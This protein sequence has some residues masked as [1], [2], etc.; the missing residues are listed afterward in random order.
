MSDNNT[1]IIGAGITGLAAAHALRKAGQTP[2]VLESSDRAGGRIKTVSYRGD[3]AEAGGQGIHTNYTEMYKL[4]DEHRLLGDLIP[5]PERTLYIDKKG[6]PRISRVKEDLALMVGPRGIADLL[7]FRRRV[8]SKTNANPQFEIALDIP[9]YDNV[10]AADGFRKYGTAFRDFVLKTATH[11]MANTTPEETNLYY[12]M[13]AVKL[14]LSTEISSL[15]GGNQRILETMAARHDMRYGVKVDKL[16]TS[17]GRVDGVLLDNGQTMKAS[18]VIVTTPAPIA[19]SLLT[20][21]FQPVK[22][23]LDSFPETPL[24]LVFF[25]LDRPLSNGACRF[26]GHP[27]RD[28]VFNMGMNHAFKTPHL[29]PSGKAI[30]SAW[31]AFPGTLELIGKSN[32]E[33]I[34]QAL[35]EMELFVPGISGWVDHAEVVRHPWG[36]A[37]YPVGSVRKIL[38]FKTHA[39]ALRGVSFAGTDYEF[40]HMEA[41]ILSG[42]RAAERSLKER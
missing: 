14:A 38:D 6:R 23:F 39:A 31:P 15:A 34:A 12:T 2:I 33:V 13:N 40:I 41:G 30:I 3:A 22:Q 19:G 5:A 27:Y 8:F 26:F 20:D 32:A 17:G 42:Y 10:T 35:S 4:L 11:A 37:R 29:S 36:V 18:H 7:A 9:E 16:L 25:F 28:A 24:P 1:I 21:E